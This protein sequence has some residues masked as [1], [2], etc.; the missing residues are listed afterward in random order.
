LGTVIGGIV[1]GVA[2]LLFGPSFDEVRR[3]CMQKFVATMADTKVRAI[4]EFESSQPVIEKHLRS[5]LEK[6]LSTAT[7]QYGQ[8]IDSIIAEER[9]RIDEERANLSHLVQIRS[10]MIEHL[11]KIEQLIGTARQQSRGL[12][13]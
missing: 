7:S 2:G 10:Q 9:H 8:W 12:A 11:Q 6:T 5:V 13:K 3:N 4:R 1:G